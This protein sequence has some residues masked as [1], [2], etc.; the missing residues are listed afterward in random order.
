MFIT[1]EGEQLGDQLRTLD[2]TCPCEPQFVS[3]LSHIRRDAR[4]AVRQ[5]EARTKYVWADEPAYLKLQADTRERLRK[6]A[7]RL[8][9]AWDC[10]KLLLDEESPDFMVRIV[11][12][13]GK[14]DWQGG[15][16]VA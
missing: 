12:P 16:G 11:P 1:L 6:H 14:G 10:S 5:A 15:V 13:N 7:E 8:A 2:P 9:Q 3:L 4:M